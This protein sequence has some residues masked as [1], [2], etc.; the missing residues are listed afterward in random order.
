M[1]ATTTNTFNDIPKQAEYPPIITTGNLNEHDRPYAEFGQ[2]ELSELARIGKF[3]FSEGS[4][5]PKRFHFNAKYFSG[6]A[7]TRVSLRQVNYWLCTSW[8]ATDYR[9]QCLII[10]GDTG[11]GKTSFAM[12]LPGLVNYYK[13]EWCLDEWNNDA[14]YMVIDDVAW[15][16][17]EDTWFPDKKG[18]LGC[19]EDLF[20]P[21]KHQGARK[22]RVR[23]PAIMLL[24]YE[25][26]GS[27]LAKPVTE[28]QKATA[29][30]WEERAFVIQMQPGERFCVPKRLPIFDPTDKSK[31]NTVDHLPEFAESNRRWL[32][33]QREIE[34]ETTITPI[35]TIQDHI[36]ADTTEETM[37][38][39]NVTT[40]NND[41]TIVLNKSTNNIQVIKETVNGNK[42]KKK[43]CN[44]KY[45]TIFKP[46]IKQPLRRSQRKM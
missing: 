37:N 7:I 31:Y 6:S 5:N 11:T 28:E 22:I 8:I 27:L 3:N 46:K 26:A 14:R 9:G 15:D 33:Q 44:R 42:S 19:N 18:M 12:S 13:G 20:A 35:P 17:Y 34:V 4:A 38:T 16:E 32:Q 39:S 43:G 30:Y 25:N 1:I 10:I 45:H 29:R 40:D 21:D 23:M 24:N 2:S 41:T 36:T